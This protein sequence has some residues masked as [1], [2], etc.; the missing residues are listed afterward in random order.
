MNFRHLLEDLKK[1]CF[2]QYMGQN[3]LTDESNDE[4]KQK[5]FTNI[6]I[7]LNLHLKDNQGRF[8]HVHFSNNSFFWGTK[9]E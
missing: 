7:G 1:T 4:T 8:V 3:P 9:E 6:G 5:N 2:C